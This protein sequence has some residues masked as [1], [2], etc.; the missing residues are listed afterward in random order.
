MTDQQK[1]GAGL[2]ARLGAPRPT[3]RLGAASHNLAALGPSQKAALVIAALGADAAGPIIERISDKHLRAF[4][5]AYANLQAMPK[6]A[7]QDVAKEFIAGLT[8]DDDMIRG[9]REETRAL[10]SQF[11][12]ENGVNRAMGES[13]E[14]SGGDFWAKLDAAE[15][16]A[17]ATYLAQ[18]KPQLAAVILTRIDPEKASRVLDQFETSVAGQILLRLSKPLKVNDAAMKILCETIEREFLTQEETSGAAYDPGDLIGSMMN[19]IMSDKREELLKF[20]GES[21]PDI[22]HSVKKSMLTFQDVAVRVP[23]KAIPLA[24]K[25]MELEL[26]LQAVKYGA[27]NAPESVEFIMGNIS[28][29][30][31]TQYKEQMEELKPVTPKE[32]EAAQAAFMSVIRKLAAAGEVT[33]VEPAPEE[34]ADAEEDAA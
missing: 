4:T 8:R 29:R 34:T 1:A 6:A 21:A 13:E 33:L 16:E 10:L 17:L 19:N 24:V 11:L 7:L 25:A 3:N 18:Q 14:T 23:P 27:T 31:A 26:F 32:A 12:D 20:I 9:G 15:D 28:Q 30:M 5:K 2:P 22:L